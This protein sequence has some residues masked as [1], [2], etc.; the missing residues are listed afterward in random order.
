MCK[1]SKLSGTKKF[2]DHVEN[3]V[4]KKFSCDSCQKGFSYQHILD[5]HIHKVHGEGQ[6]ERLRCAFL[7][8]DFETKYRQTL[9]AHVREK[10]EGKKKIIKPQGK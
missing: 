6:N 10:H 9:A 2:F 4:T 3:H 5:E 8:C 7:D 1:A